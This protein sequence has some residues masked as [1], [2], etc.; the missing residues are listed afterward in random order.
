MLMPID[1]SYTV[2]KSINML[3]ISCRTFSSSLSIKPH[4]V[5][6]VNERGGTGLSPNELTCIPALSNSSSIDPAT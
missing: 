4:L 3:V 6:T 5:T 1:V 2:A